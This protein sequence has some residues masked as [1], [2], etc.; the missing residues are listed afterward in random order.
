MEEGEV[1]SSDTRRRE[2]FFQL[3]SRQQINNIRD[4]SVSIPTTKKIKSEN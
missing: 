3:V 2:E 4:K 1:P